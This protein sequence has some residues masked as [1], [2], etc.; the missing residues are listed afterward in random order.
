MS[1][2]R[3]LRRRT[4]E[5]KVRHASEQDGLAALRSLRRSGDNDVM[6]VYHCRFCGGWHTGHTPG[7][8]QR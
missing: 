4:C 6:N 7:Q 3:R 8:H 5:R 2:K 1:S